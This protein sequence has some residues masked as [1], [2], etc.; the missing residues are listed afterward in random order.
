[1]ETTTAHTITLPDILRL[2]PRLDEFAL[3]D[4]FLLYEVGGDRIEKSKTALEAIQNPIR[5]DGYFCMYC[6]QG[7]FR[8]DVNLRSYDIHPDSIFINVPGN[9]TKITDVRTDRLSDYNFIFVLVSRSFMQNIRF[10]FSKSFQDSIRILQTPVITLNPH[11][12]EIAEDY[13]RLALK[14]LHAPVTNR[15]EVIGTLISSLTYMAAD[16]WQTAFASAP[17]V[18]TGTPDRLTL[19]F[20]R[21]IALVSEHCTRHRTVGFYAEQLCLTPK[22]LSKLIREVSGRSAPDWID[23][24][25]ILEAKN[26]LK[27]SDISIKEVVYKLNFPNPSVFHAFFKARTG[28]TPTEY[29]KGQKTD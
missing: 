29:R 13:L 25:V 6:L 28:L 12:R 21:F 8:M 7:S 17:A 5:F 14:I 1:M 27:Y 15:K 2:Y 20:D 4:D 16:V 11:Q 3:G 24:F 23:S 9:I 10:D 26:L 18:Q 22:Y 19:L